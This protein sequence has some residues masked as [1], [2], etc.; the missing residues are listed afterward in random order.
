VLNEKEQEIP[1]SPSNQPS[2]NNTSI[3]IGEN[4][5][6]SGVVIYLGQPKSSN[7][8]AQILLDKN[9]KVIGEI[10]CN[11]NLELL[12]AVSGSVFTSNFV[13]KQAGSI[14][15][16]HIYNGTIIVD[17]LAQEYVGLPFEQSTKGVLKWLY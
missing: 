16:N 17:D 10:Y 11:Q 7:Y 8:E 12:G 14:Y 4:T 6:L 15:Q 1:Q 5:T 9:S 13:A 3:T 2:Q